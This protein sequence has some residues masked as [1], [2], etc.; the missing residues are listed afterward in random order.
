MKPTG[1][2]MRFEIFGE[3]AG[4]VIPWVAF[5][6]FVILGV[7][8][9]VLDGSRIMLV[10]RQLQSATDAAALAGARVM[11]DGDYTGSAIAYSAGS[12]KLNASA[13][14]SAST[15]IV[16]PICVSALKTQGLPCVNSASGNA[17]Q[18]QQSATVSTFFMGMVG[19]K[20]VKI[21]TVSTAAMGGTNTPYNVAIILDTTPSMDYPDSSCGTNQTQL[22]CATKGIQQLL[23][24]LSPSV[25]HV[26]LFTFPN[27]D[28]SDVS[29]D[30]DCSSTSNPTAE[31]YT[32][33]SNSAKSLSNT[34]FSTGSGTSKV[35]TNVTYQITGFSTDYRSSNSTTS[36]SKSSSLSNALGVGTGTGG[37]HH[38]SSGCSGIQTSSENTYYAGA[39]YAAQSALLAE[40]NVNAGTQNV[41]ILLSD[42]NATAQ[43]S[44]MANSSNSNSS[45]TWAT[46]S[47]TYP[48]WIGECG[49]GVD[50]AK[51]AATYPGNPTKVYTIA[52]G[53]PTTSNLSNC[54]SDVGQG[55]HPNI[56]PCTA[57]KLMASSPQNF[58]SDYYMTGGDPA[59]QATGLPDYSLNGIFQA[60]A[61]QLT[62]VRLI[63]NGM[64]TTTP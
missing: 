5:M 58:Y 55:A 52:Y 48:S 37:R 24:N 57:M 30:T 34:V 36:L 14:Y 8:G 23:L 28:A 11:P 46:N 33:P 20:T 32:F 6:M 42:G 51:Y 35:T 26:S 63:P 41:I 44:N 2:A 13:T 53:S 60:I 10:H 21:S 56:S 25:D 31:P 54:G 3:D 50:A 59:C 22:S 62:T 49:Q 9:L 15:P 27:I 12:G 1:S 38:S 47:G 18:V 45:T 61:Y 19:M 43:Q 17:L 64:A 29:M 7:S 16:T 39:I 4:Q 40:Q